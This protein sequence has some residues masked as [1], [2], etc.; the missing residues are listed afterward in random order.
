MILHGS[1]AQR[2]AVV[3]QIK[4][5][6]ELFEIM[7]DDGAEWAQDLVRRSLFQKVCV[8][9]LVEC[10]KIEKWAIT[11]R[12]HAFSIKNQENRLKQN[13]I[14]NSIGKSPH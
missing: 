13:Q 7:Q 4:K 11:D 8:M 9:Q 12:T 6:Y 2:T 5:D 1:D 14:R 10:L 3:E